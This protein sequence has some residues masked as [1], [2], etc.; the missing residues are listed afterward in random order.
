VLAQGRTRYTHPCVGSNTSS[1]LLVLNSHDAQL[2][3][4]F[5][6]MTTEEFS[7]P[8]R[9]ETLWNDLSEIWQHVCLHFTTWIVTLPPP[10]STIL[11]Q[12]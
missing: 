12:S 10:R 11:L 7:N 4:D 8:L 1:V 9:R 5:N 3:T 6:A 2:S